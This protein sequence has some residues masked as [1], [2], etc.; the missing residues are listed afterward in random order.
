[1]AQLTQQQWVYWLILGGF[2]LNLI[3]FSWWLIL[4][5]MV[6]QPKTKRINSTFTIPEVSPAVAQAILQE[7]DSDVSGLTGEIL[8]AIRTGEVR[9]AGSNDLKLIKVTPISNEFLAT[10]FAQIAQGDDLPLSA[11]KTYAK[12]DKTSQ[13]GQWFSRWRF[14]IFLQLTPYKNARNSRI[15]QVWLGFA[16]MMS[17]WLVIAFYGGCFVA[18][19]IGFAT[20]GRLLP[21]VVIIWSLAL[22]QQ[23]R[24]RAEIAAGLALQAQVRAFREKLV[25][26]DKVNMVTMGDLSVWEQVLPYAAAFGLSKRVTSILAI[27]FGVDAVKGMQTTYPLLGATDSLAT[28]LATPIKRALIAALEWSTIKL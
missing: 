28:D 3:G 8:D 13:L 14:S 23:N 20:G 1:M 9:V 4:H 2:L 22:I 5:R 17:L 25:K 26:I 12:Q 6:F 7:N 18:I 11:L 16:V 15:R 21:V 19:S 10:C 27:D 24:I